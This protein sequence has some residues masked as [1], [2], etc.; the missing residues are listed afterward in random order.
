MFFV[1]SNDNDFKI[2]P[3]HHAGADFHDDGG[4]EVDTMVL[5]FGV[6]LPE[7][8][9]LQAP[10][11][12]GRMVRRLWAVARFTRSR[13]SE[14]LLQCIIA[15]MRHIVL[16]ALNPGHGAICAIQ[17]QRLCDIYQICKSRREFVAAFSVS[18]SIRSTAKRN[19]T[20]CRGAA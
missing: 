18:R 16:V 20:A 8:A 7:L 4:V 17:P 6:T 2:Q 10:S 15:I 19:E 5:V 3:G 11:A 9:Q 13:A 12:I 14:P 1:I